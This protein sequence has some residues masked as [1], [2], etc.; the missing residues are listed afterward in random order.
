MKMKY[1][2]T[3]KLVI[4]QKYHELET[5]DRDEDMKLRLQLLRRVQMHRFQSKVY[6]LLPPKMC[7]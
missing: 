1:S 5:Y 2:K 4:I 6:E 7:S 3:L